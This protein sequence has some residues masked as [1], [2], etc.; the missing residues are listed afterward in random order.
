MGEMPYKSWNQPYEPVYSSNWRMQSYQPSPGWNAPSNAP[1]F[2]KT[3]GYEWHR[4]SASNP[5]VWLAVGAGLYY[6]FARR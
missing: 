4:A 3:Y 2:G 1:L 5:L 6:L